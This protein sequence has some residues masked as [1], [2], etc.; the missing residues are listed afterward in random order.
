MNAA[1]RSGRGG[2]V[3]E[4]GLSRLD[5]VHEARTPEEREA[6]YAF[7]YTV[8]VEELGRELG[9]ADHVHRVVRDDEDEAVGSIHLYTGPIDAISGAVRLRIWKPGQVP[10]HEFRMLAMDHFPGIRSMAVSELGRLM[11]RPS[12]RGRLLL[13]ALVREV[14]VR[15]ASAGVDLGFCYCAPGLVQ[16]YRKLGFRPYAAPLVPTVDGLHVPLVGIP[17]DAAYL[18]SVGSPVA[19]LV[20]RYYGEGAGRRRPIDITDLEGL[21][22]THA[23]AVEL[24]TEQ[25]WREVQDGLTRTAVSSVLDGLDETAVRTLTAKGFMLTVSGDTLV[26]RAGYGEREMYVVIDGTLDVLSASEQRLGVLGRGD[27]FGELAFF[28]DDGRRTASVRAISDSH[29]LV[30]RR[31][32]LDELGR[33]DPDLALR[34]YFNLGRLLAERVVRAELRSGGR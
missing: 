4:S 21:L 19:P 2:F 30:L 32:F 14:Y 5:V 25:V 29:L 6:V 33:S 1:A 10:G 24:D 8:Y 17:S 23:S 31:H 3:F 28:R 16:H 26:T 12:L 22:D 11:I 34:L 27:L 9:G 20:S 13:P 18:R 15:G 7:R